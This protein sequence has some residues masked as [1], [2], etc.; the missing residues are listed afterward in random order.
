MSNTPDNNR[1]EQDGKFKSGVSGNPAGRPIGTK[2][3]VSQ[4]VNDMMAERAEEITNI[5]IDNALAGDSGCLRLVIERLAPAP[6]DNR[7]NIELPTIENA[8]DLNKAISHIIA[9]VGTGD[10]TP[11][12]GQ[13]L[14]KMFEGWKA[15]Y[16]LEEIEQRI[17][18]LEE[19]NNGK[20]GG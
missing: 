5:L 13:S 17:N 19:H 7:I 18:K 10:I 20:S 15:A 4:L 2:S 14:I 9:K 6:K 16:S 1:K 3:K 8:E 11:L 12:E